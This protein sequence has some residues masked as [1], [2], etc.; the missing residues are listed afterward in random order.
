MAPNETMTES[1]RTSTHGKK[2]IADTVGFK[3]GMGVGMTALGAI[4]LFLA[5]WVFRH[6]RRRRSPG[7][8]S[9][10]PYKQHSV[11][12]VA[13]TEDPYFDMNSTEPI[14]MYPGPSRS[15]VRIPAP[16]GNPYE[17][18]SP[19]RTASPAST[20]SNNY[21]AFPLGFTQGRMGV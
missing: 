6:C 15:T 16:A 12:F 5:W 2:P 13:P 20:A 10:P 17:A 11:P 4:I 1:N 9:P 8:N 19:S 18:L 3:A 7:R 21:G 14:Q